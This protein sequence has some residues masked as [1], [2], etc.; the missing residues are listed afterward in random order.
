MSDSDKKACR[1]V[2]EK[3]QVNPFQECIKKAWDKAQMIAAWHAWALGSIVR[4]TKQE[5]KQERNKQNWPQKAIEH[6]YR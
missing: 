4:S 1:E 5:K 2:S 3:L 6:D